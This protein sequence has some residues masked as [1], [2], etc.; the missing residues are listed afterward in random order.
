MD[1]V[2]RVRLPGLDRRMAQRL[3]ARGALKDVARKLQRNRRLRVRPSAKKSPT[4]RTFWKRNIHPAARSPFEKS[5]AK[6]GGKWYL[7]EAPL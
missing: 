4:K 3:A 2:G 5:A 6:R 7:L 1:A